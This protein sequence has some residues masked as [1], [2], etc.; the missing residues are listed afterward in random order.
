[1]FQAKGTEWTKKAGTWREQVPWAES[2]KM[3]NSQ[4]MPSSA[5]HRQELGFD[6]KM[7]GNKCFKQ[8]FDTTRSCGRDYRCCGEKKF[9]A[10]ES[11]RVRGAVSTFGGAA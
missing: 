11:F 9:I 3:S 4:A 7:M 5:D 2:R 1:M 8:K 6:A 10:R